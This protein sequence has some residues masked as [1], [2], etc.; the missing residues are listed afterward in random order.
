MPDQLA[1]PRIA[2]PHCDAPYTEVPPGGEQVLTC[3]QCGGYFQPHG[4]AGPAADE[5]GD[6]APPPPISKLFEPTKAATLDDLLTEE[7]KDLLAVVEALHRQ[8]AQLAETSAHLRSI[9]S[10]L[11]IVALMGAVG[12]VLAIVKSW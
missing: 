6:A 7:R 11:A 3:P 12:L 5:A 2:C 8:E 4:T 9:R 10:W 1:E